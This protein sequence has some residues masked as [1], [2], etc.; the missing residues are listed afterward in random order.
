[1]GS[2]MRNDRSHTANT[3]SAGDSDGVHLFLREYREY[4]GVM[5]K[6]CKLRASTD[7]ALT[8]SSK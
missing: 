2:A 3:Y 5:Q 7:K 6:R 4:G 8:H 1:M